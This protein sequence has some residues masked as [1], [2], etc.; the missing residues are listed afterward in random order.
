MNVIHLKTM[1]NNGFLPNVNV[2]T[3]TTGK[4]TTKTQCIFDM[5]IDEIL[6]VQNLQ[7]VVLPTVHL[8]DEVVPG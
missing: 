8:Q 7:L 3:K 5:E 2:P 6:G 1:S 4:C